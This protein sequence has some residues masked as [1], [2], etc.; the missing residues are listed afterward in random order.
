MEKD[1]V[2][3]EV[4]GIT[5][6]DEESPHCGNTSIT[7]SDK[8][9]DGRTSEGLQQ[10]EKISHHNSQ[11]NQ[12]PAMTQVTNQVDECGSLEAKEDFEDE[13]QCDDAADHENLHVIDQEEDEAAKEQH[14]NGGSGWRSEG[15]GRRF[16]LRGAGL[17]PEQVN[18]NAFP[19]MQK[20][21]VAASGGRHKQSRRRN[22]HHHH[23]HGRG[24][25]RSGKQLL[26]AFKEML[27]ES[28]SVWCVSCV[29][30]MIEIIVTL[31]HN[32]GVGV[33]RGGVKVYNFVQHF[34][35]KITD[36]A[37]MK[38]ETFRIFQRTKG[39][40]MHLLDKLLRSVK[41]S[42]TAALTGWHLFLALIVFGFY[43]GKD[44]FSRLLGGEK[45]RRCWSAFQESRFW[46]RVTSLKEKVLSRL[47]KNGPMPS[48][49][50]GSP[51]RSARCQPGQELERL[52][53][54]SEVPEDE[55]DPFAVLGVEV[56][57]TDA[58]LKKAYRQLA[59]QVCKK[60]CFLFLFLH[61]S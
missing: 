10:E 3:K 21:N 39:I 16:K 15:V 57:A 60:I 34:L 20:S 51:N 17:V 25:R 52:L 1:T 29:H 49:I 4:D 14:L 44:L 40:G 2:E 42:E 11:D 9:E 12:N 30:M 13:E 32:C 33:E 55:L 53:A 28:V 41:W 48:S 46:K 18:H 50:P 47:R 26:L 59:V 22:H 56:H 23:Q 54:M 43:W 36:V 7:C 58:E 38:A 5:D 61:L 24:R 31:T 45:A 6:T 19:Y 37:E 35:V 27:S 8:W